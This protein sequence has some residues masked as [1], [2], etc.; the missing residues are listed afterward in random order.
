MTTRLTKA[1]TKLEIDRLLAVGLRPTEI[2]KEL[3]ISQ[4]KYYRYVRELRDDMYKPEAIAQHDKEINAIW[5]R[6]KNNTIRY[7]ENKG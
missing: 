4:I 6:R 7:T 1:K 3:N 2:M 5:N